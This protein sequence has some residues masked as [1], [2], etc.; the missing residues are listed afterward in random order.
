VT[1]AVAERYGLLAERRGRMRLIEKS[2]A[3]GKIVLTV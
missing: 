2:H 1:V 3:P